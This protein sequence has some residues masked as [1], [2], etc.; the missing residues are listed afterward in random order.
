MVYRSDLDHPNSMHNNLTNQASMQVQF[1]KTSNQQDGV[2]PEFTL[3][4]YYDK[5]AVSLKNGFQTHNNKFVQPVDKRLFNQKENFNQA[6]QNNMYKPNEELLFEIQQTQ[7]MS[8]FQRTKRQANVGQGI[9]QQVEEIS[10]SGYKRQIQA[11]S[12]MNQSQ[13]M[14]S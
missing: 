4:G 8:E 11:N 5:E 14:S 3:N 6:N 1:P 7:K 10:P 13:Q 12:G 9:E 2:Q